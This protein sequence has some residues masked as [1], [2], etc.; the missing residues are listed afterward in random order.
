MPVGQGIAVQRAAVSETTKNTRE[1]HSMKLHKLV[2]AA[3]PLLAATTQAQALTAQG[4]TARWVQANLFS[5]VIPHSIAGA[6]ALL[7]L[8]APAP[9]DPD[10]GFVA[11]A[12]TSA[13]RVNFFDGSDVQIGSFASSRIMDPF[14]PGDP[15]GDA[16]FAVSVTGT[17]LVPTNADYS[18][19]VLSDDGFDFRIDGTTVFE[20]DSD[21][22]PGTSRV[23][24]VALTA[25]A[26]P[27]EL[28]GWEQGGQFVL[29]LTWAPHGTEDFALVSSVPTPAALPLMAAALMGLAGHRRRR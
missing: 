22:G 10:N 14:T 20:L 18:F 25:G 7:A 13:D 15:G 29:E 17:L 24:L 12:A 1:H 11:A 4:I 8:E 3:L 5:S 26:H 19:V 6:E 21:R 28:I 2:L 9:G 16:R 27:F 23:D